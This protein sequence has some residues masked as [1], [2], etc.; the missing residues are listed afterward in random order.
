MA[1]RR[2]QALHARVGRALE[3][4]FPATVDTQP[5]ILAHHFMQAGLV[6]PAIEYW[7]RAG[8]RNVR[9]SAHSEACA[10]FRLALDLLRKLPPSRQR[11]VRELELMLALAVPLIAAQGFGSA[12]VEQCAVQAK[13]LSDKLSE[14]PNRFAAQRLAWNSC[15]MR[16]PVPK[17]VTGARDLL[18]LAEGHKDAAKV[19]VAHRALG[20]SLL[21]A[22]ELR[23]AND[24]LDRG[25]ALAD[26]LSD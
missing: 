18:E 9:R 26:S 13:E 12:N 25:R 3:D 6:E 7:H 19:A 22:G 15:L 24:I 21:I 23:S 4:N 17:T 20:Y 8:T 10:Q 5:E 14:S 11:D 1:R 2:R 16:R